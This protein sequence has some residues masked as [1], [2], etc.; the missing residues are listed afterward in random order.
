MKFYSTWNDV[1]DLGIDDSAFINSFIS[2]SE[3]SLDSLYFGSDKEIKC[4]IAI[5]STIAESDL[6]TSIC[7]CVLPQ[8]TPP[9]V[10]CFSTFSNGAARINELLEFSPSGLTYPEIGKQLTG[11]SS[12]YAQI[13]YGENH[14]KL[15]AMMSLVTISDQKPATV[16]ATALGHYLVTVPYEEKEL[17]LKK[18]L[19]RDPCIQSIVQKAVGGS[20]NYRTI[21][22]T[23]SETTAYR[24]RTSVKCLVEFALGISNTRY[25]L[26]RIDW[27]L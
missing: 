7:N 16:K 15:A 9:D 20:A 24:R 13:K 21:V 8:L 4:A 11:S 3:I 17:I 27:E 14:A 5:L 1:R 18:L 10:P 2:R 19:L 25:L 12:Q 26:E 23:L 6:I 22:E